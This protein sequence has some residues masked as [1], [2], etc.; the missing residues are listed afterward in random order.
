M[1]PQEKDLK[2]WLHPQQTWFYLR[3]SQG[4]TL[5]FT[6]QAMALRTK[7]MQILIG[8]NIFLSQETNTL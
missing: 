8:S 4:H 5:A 6:L 2:H 1:R 7:T 3:V